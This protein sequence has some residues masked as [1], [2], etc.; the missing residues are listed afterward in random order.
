MKSLR[1]ALIL[2]DMYPS[3]SGVGRS[4]QTQIEELTRLGHQ[5]TLLAPSDNLVPPQNA[6]AIPLAA[7]RFPGLPLHT[8]ILKS[9]QNVAK[10]ICR[11]H[12][13]DV[14]HS[15]TDTGAVTLAARIAK[16][17]GIPHIH[18]FHTNIA[19][20]HRVMPF[21]TFLASL[22]Y[23]LSAYKLRRIS[24]R[25]PRLGRL[26][27]SRGLTGQNFM[28][29]FDWRSQALMA[30]AMS[31][32][33]TP[34][35]F[36][37]R[38]IR[39]AAPNLELT[40]ANVPTGYNRTL[41]D[42]IDQVKSPKTDSTLRFISISRIVKEKRLDVMI[43]AFDRADLPNSELLIVGDGAELARLKALAKNITGVK[44]TGH[45][46]Q[47]Q[48]IVRHLKNSS[49]FVLASHRFDNQ[50]IVITESLVAGVPLLYCDDQLDVGLNPENSLL[51]GESAE[52]LAEG[53][54][55]LADPAFRQQLASGTK[56]VLTELSPE[57]TAKNYLKLYTEVIDSYDTN[58]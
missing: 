26:A 11:Q 17:Q 13:F 39:A 44:F 19:G 1:I 30:S 47:R 32:V 10:Q 16:L 20:T 24:G 43:E 27:K 28:E 34:S 40:G 52:E 56:S 51:V 15:Q 42:S 58:Q 25:R 18:T 22:G 41:K 38:F 48:D 7:I 12:K 21:L 33:T 23:R 53:M 6:T 31:A 57:T 50:P 8:R 36:M 35:Q 3:S 2:D 4:I 46:S 55:K 37:L 9:S 14:I 29:R 5:V 49:V 54:K 45:V